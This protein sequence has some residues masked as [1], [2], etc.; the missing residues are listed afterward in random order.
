[1]SLD[2]FSREKPETL[3][4]KGSLGISSPNFFSTATPKTELQLSLPAAS[5][6]GVINLFAKASQTLNPPWAPWS[7][8]PLTCH[9]QFPNWYSLGVGQKCSI[10][11]GGWTQNPGSLHA[12]LKLVAARWRKRGISIML[13]SPRSR[14]LQLGSQRLYSVPSQFSNCPLPHSPCTTPKFV[15]TLPGNHCLLRVNQVAS[16]E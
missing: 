12:F 15:Q 9:I 10:S 5:D 2:P 8:S 4:R 11:L 1:M 7:V 13:G 14:H 16:T 3:K 6:S